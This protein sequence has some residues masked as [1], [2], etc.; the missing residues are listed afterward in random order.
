MSWLVWKPF[1]P[2]PVCIKYKKNPWN[3]LD[4]KIQQSL[5]NVCN[6][7]M[8]AERWAINS[9][10]CPGGN[11]YYYYYRLFNFMLCSLSHSTTQPASH[12]CSVF[13]C[14]AV[15]YFTIKQVLDSNYRL[16]L[17]LLIF[18][19]VKCKGTFPSYKF[20]Q[21]FGGLFHIFLNLDLVS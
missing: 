10:L 16:D 6:D 12:L 7:G 19:L 4:N 11:I 21:F 15:L 1:S 3:I 20:L 18:L 5:I 17:F 9:E 8:V 13:A 2:P 14:T